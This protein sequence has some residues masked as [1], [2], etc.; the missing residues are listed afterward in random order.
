VSNISNMFEFCL[1]DLTVA[2]DGGGYAYEGGRLMI[3]NP[4]SLHVRP[5]FI[6]QLHLIMLFELLSGQNFQF[7]YFQFNGR[8]LYHCSSHTC[9]TD[10]SGGSGLEA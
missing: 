8:L 10:I 2:S 1:L 6:L 5:I 7:Q 9:D 4:M 3:L